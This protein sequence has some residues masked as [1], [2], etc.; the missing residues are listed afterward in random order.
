M[1]FNR[2]HTL[3]NLL[4]IPLRN[5]TA[6]V[7]IFL[8][9]LCVSLIYCI[10]T[11]AIYRAE[12]R[13][14][15]T[16]DEPRLSDLDQYRPVSY[17]ARSLRGGRNIASEVEIV[18]GEYLTEKVV[19]RV[20]NRIKPLGTGRT[21]IGRIA[22]ALRSASRFALAPLGLST[23]PSDPAKRM[24]LTFL[25]RLHVANPS[26]TD[27]ISIAFDWTDPHSAALVANTYADE[28]AIQQSLV[29]DS[30]RLSQFYEDQAGLLEKRLQEADAQYQTL[31]SGSHMAE[32]GLQRDLFIRNLA[33]ITS[34]INSTDAEIKEI[35]ARMGKIR[36][37]ARKPNVWVE[38]AGSRSDRRNGY[39]RSLDGLY[40]SL[41]EEKEFLLRDHSSDDPEVRAIDKRLE[42]VR[43]QKIDGALEVAAMD[44]SI[45]EA[46]KSIL[47]RQ[48]GAEQKKLKTINSRI[49][50]LERLER[51]R[52]SIEKEY[53]TYSEKA[54]NLRIT[55]DL[56][57]NK[58]S[59]V[60]VLIPA[61]PP[62]APS[63]P[64]KWAII[65]FSALGGLVLGLLFSAI[66]EF[67]NHTFRE[68]HEVA[69]ILDIPLLL[70]VPDQAHG[71]AV[72]SRRGTINGGV[73]RLR[74]LF[75][76]ELRRPLWGNGSAKSGAALILGLVL[77][78][79]CI[80]YLYRPFLSPDPSAAKKIFVPVRN[81][82]EAVSLSSIYPVVWSN[83]VDSE[84]PLLVPP[85]AG[86]SLLSEELEK[87]RSDLYRRHQEVEAK[88]RKARPEGR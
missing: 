44:L 60:K 72:N 40:A 61:V 27:M 30:S 87:Q 74:R 82:E 8:A 39:L 35:R 81:D 76:Q 78:A 15:V 13:L 51:E 11:P 16:G 85:E 38:N 88:L 20:N 50:A 52:S 10:V 68:D 49:I 4:H 23:S 67:F 34:R 24:I 70:T 48:L 69:R 36:E 22:D 83:S 56:E 84:L 55:N 32:P 33:D 6:V 54:E 42:S 62:I 71:P 1:K 65:L 37:M 41:R 12:T 58:I 64:R 80:F 18:K 59:A 28:Y 46:R 2:T 79:A 66:K 75:G 43:I 86:S 3:R 29:N 9:A 19:T 21:A 14:V 5:R 53:R 17:V 25:D 57:A 63:Y 47:T 45:A 26:G 77:A 7:T 31:L 73:A